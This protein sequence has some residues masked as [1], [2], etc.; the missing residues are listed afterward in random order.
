MHRVD[1]NITDT[2]YFVAGAYSPHEND[3]SATPEFASSLP[4]DDRWT[5]SATADF[6][7]P[8]RYPVAHIACRP[9]DAGV[10]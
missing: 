1:V 10:G 4:D 2:I 9:Q 8:H 5:N 6:N 3:A 7:A